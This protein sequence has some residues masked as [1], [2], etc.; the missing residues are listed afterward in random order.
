MLDSERWNCAYCWTTVDPQEFGEGL[1]IDVHNGG[2]DGQSMAAHRQCFVGHLSRQMTLGPLLE[3]PDPVTTTA[4]DG[5]R[6]PPHD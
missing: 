3:A 5:P 6:Q 2:K 4:D 1:Y